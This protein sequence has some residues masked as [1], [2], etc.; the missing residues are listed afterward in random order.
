VVVAIIQT[1][2]LKTEVEKGSMWTV[3]GH[4][5]LDPKAMQKRVSYSVL[6]SGQKGMRLI[7]LK[8]EVDLCGNASELGDVG[9]YFWKSYL[10]FLTP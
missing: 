7:F 5:L 4:G 8:L 2:I 1:R 6:L 3:N 9:A 10:F